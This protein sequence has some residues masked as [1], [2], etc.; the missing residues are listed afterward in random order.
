MNKLIQTEIYKSIHNKYFA[1][2][3]I[4]AFIIQLFNVYPYYVFKNE[5]LAFDLEQINKGIATPKAFFESLD[6]YTFWMPVEGISMGSLLAKYLLPILSVLPFGWAFLIEQ[7]SGY[8]MQ[9][10][11]RMG[12]ARYFISKYIA[13]FISGA[14]P[15]AFMLLSNYAV[16]ALFFPLHTPSV[17][18]LSTGI[19]INTF[20]G[21]LFY[22]NAFLFMLMWTGISAIWGGTLAGLTMTVSLFLK[23]SIFVMLFPFFITILWDNICSLIIGNHSLSFIHLFYLNNQ[24]PFILF[25][26]ILI[27]FLLSFGGG[28]IYY[29]KKDVL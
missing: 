19:D 27:L 22:Q 20:G 10:V 23:N 14:F 25:G 17:D 8:Q 28:L 24:S 26:E 21:T 13:T 7:I 6:I 15:I 2:S 4:T 16:L 1:I 12:K 29:M 3:M 18:S 5:A 11:C 9:T